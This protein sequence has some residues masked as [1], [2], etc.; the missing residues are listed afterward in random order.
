MMADVYPGVGAMRLGAILK[1][2]FQGT[3][4]IPDGIHT[5][6]V[7]GLSGDMS[8]KVTLDVQPYGG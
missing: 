4:G 7:I 8:D 3:P 2:H 5:L 1:L 6:R